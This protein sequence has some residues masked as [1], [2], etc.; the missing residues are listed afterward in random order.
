MRV[1]FWNIG[2]G[3]AS[4]ICWEEARDG[5]ER[6]DLIDLG[7]PGTTQ[8]SEYFVPGAGVRSWRI[9]NLVLTHNDA[10]HIGGLTWLKGKDSHVDVGRAFFLDD[11]QGRPERKDSLAWLVR[12]VGPGNA[13]RLEAPMTIVAHGDY[14]LDVLYPS[15]QENMKYEGSPNDTS[16]IL[17]LA[18]KGS[19]LVVWGGD[20]RLKRLA[21]V[22]PHGPIWLFGPHHGGPQDRVKDAFPDLVS[23]IAP[24]N[25]LLSF[26]TNNGYGHP[27][28]QYVHALAASEC[29]LTCIQQAGQCAAKGEGDILPGDGFLGLWSPPPPAVQCHGH[30]RLRIEDGRIVDELEEEYAE[31]KSRRGKRLCAPSPIP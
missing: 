13:G 19:P 31:M 3:D 23:A 4:S 29:G 10:D 5:V 11:W 14:S 1:D 16:G 25:C 27:S 21:G 9:D 2:Q 30:V 28:P 18:W 15:F 12:K 6:L 22:S 7:P 8:L 26:G 24:R 17:V 20:N